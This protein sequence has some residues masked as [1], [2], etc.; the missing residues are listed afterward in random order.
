MTN[1]SSSKDVFEGKLPKVYWKHIEAISDQDIQ[2]ETCRIRQIY[3]GLEYSDLE[4]DRSKYAE[5]MGYI[6]LLAENRAYSSRLLKIHDG[7]ESA[8]KRNSIIIDEYQKGKDSLRGEVVK[9]RFKMNTVCL[10][11]ACFSGVITGLVIG[12]LASIVTGYSR[13]ACV[14]FV[15]AILVPLYFG[16]LSLIDYLLVKAE[17]ENVKEN[18]LSLNVACDF[19][20]NKCTRFRV[21]KEHIFNG[22]FEG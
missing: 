10:F 2:R 18:R 7:I 8:I 5:T 17:Y 3:L 22:N 6:H 13:W 20:R 19:G 4:D 9:Q 11:S 15:S 12:D 1:N 14:S 16:I 21:L